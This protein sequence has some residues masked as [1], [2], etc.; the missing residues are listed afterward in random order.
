MTINIVHISRYE[1]RSFQSGMDAVSMRPTLFA[2][3]HLDNQQ[4]KEDMRLNMSSLVW[5]SRGQEKSLKSDIVLTKQ[6]L[7]TGRGTTRRLWQGVKK[8][9]SLNTVWGVISEWVKLR[10]S[11][12]RWREW[13]WWPGWQELRKKVREMAKNWNQ[14]KQQSKKRQ[15][16]VKVICWRKWYCTSQTKCGLKMRPML[17][18]WNLLIQWKYSWDPM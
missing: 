1:S 5:F 7:M 16:P 18:W 2:G 15:K 9:G 10:T 4:L 8:T 17:V 14:F 11:E 13:S 3:H 12:H 6:C